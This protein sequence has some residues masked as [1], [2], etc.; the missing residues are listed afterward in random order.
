MYEFPK[1]DIN[2]FPGHMFKSSKSMMEKVKIC[3]V[4]IEV[5]D[6]RCPWTSRNHELE[7]KFK[8]K[9]K[10]IVFNKVDLIPNSY[11]SKISSHF[12]NNT[13]LFTNSV[14]GRG[15]DKI[16]PAIHALG[17]KRKFK[18]IPIAI[19]IYGMPNLGKS[20]IINK[21]VGRNRSKV[22]PLPGVTQSVNGFALD[23]DLFLLDTPGIMVPKIQSIEDGFKLAL[24]RSIADHVVPKELLV[25]YVLHLLNQR[26]MYKYVELFKLSGPVEN[27]DEIFPDPQYLDKHCHHFLDLFRRG[28]LGKVV[29]DEMPSSEVLDGK[30]S[31][32]ESIV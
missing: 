1:I 9:K 19:M 24:I 10:I 8:S 2:W 11:E 6:A 20:T 13:T 16:L 12:P 26:K 4:L 31:V 23:R 29:L 21:I 32:I 17:V 7:L 30:I 27:V 14:N 5:R 28:M 15:I 22:G 3:D 25:N 18:S